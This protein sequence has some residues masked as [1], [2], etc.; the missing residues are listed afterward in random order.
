MNHWLNIDQCGSVSIEGNGVIFLDS[1]HRALHNFLFLADIRPHLYERSQRQK[2]QQ[3]MKS[4][5]KISNLQ[6][7]CPTLKVSQRFFVATYS[8]KDCTQSL[9]LTRAISM[10]KSL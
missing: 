9:D 8:N 6:C 7:F 2:A 1:V 3:Q 5:R 4:S 10:L